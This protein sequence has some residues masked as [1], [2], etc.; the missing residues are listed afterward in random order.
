VICRIL[1]DRNF[2]LENGYLIDPYTSSEKE[3]SWFGMVSVSRL[4]MVF[5]RWAT[6]LSLL[7]FGSRSRNRF[8]DIDALA[9][10]CDSTDII[11]VID[12]LEE[13]PS[14]GY[15][16]D[17][18]HEFSTKH[19]ARSLLEAV[20]F[21]VKRRM[22]EKSIDLDSFDE[23]FLVG[24]PAESEVWPQIIADVLQKRI[25]VTYGKYAGAVGAA[26]IAASGIGVVIETADAI[27]VC[28]PNRNIQ[29]ALDLRFRTF[30]KK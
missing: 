11:P 12:I 16:S 30:L 7:A 9:E 18:L 5:N 20:V 4:G 19:V 25:N 29:P 14:E 6:I 22:L 17:L 3:G 28:L 27:K 10:A 13:S 2:G 8:K 24:G 1:P 23:V 26:R 15:V 21:C